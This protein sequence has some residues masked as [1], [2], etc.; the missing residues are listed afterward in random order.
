MRKVLLST[1]ALMAMAGA[2]SAADLPSSKAPPPVYVPPAPI[3][4]WTGFYIGIEGGGDFRRYKYRWAGADYGL[5]KD[6]GLIGGVVGYNWQMNNFVI[7]LEGDAAAVLGGDRAYTFNGNVVYS[8]RYNSNYAAAIRGR[9]GISAWDRALLY[10]AG[11][12]AFGDAEL[13]YRG[14]GYTNADYTT[15]RTGW[16]IGAGV[17][18]AMNPNW[19]ARVEYRYV[20]LGRGGYYNYGAYVNDRIE[21]TAHQVMGA[22]LY[23]FGGPTAAPVVAKY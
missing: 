10:V 1:V 20:D 23:K 19:I 13:R 3:F 11:G 2:A 6:A 16:T 18:Y 9:L 21:V 8:N 14:V 15:S 4:T 12:V 17:D 22:L 5:D 7:G